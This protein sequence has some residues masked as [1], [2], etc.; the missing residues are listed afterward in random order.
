MVWEKEMEKEREKEREK[1]L[2]GTQ[3]QSYKCST[4]YYLD[5]VTLCLKKL[6]N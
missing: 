1:E 4:D 2:N 3:I 6:K 5:Q